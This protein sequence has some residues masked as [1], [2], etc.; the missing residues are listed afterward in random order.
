[1]KWHAAT[2]GHATLCG[3]DVHHIDYRRIGDELVSD[4]IVVCIEC[5]EL[6]E[7]FVGRVGKRFG[8]R[9][10]MD[11]LKPYC[12]RRMLKVHQSLVTRGEQPFATNWETLR[13]VLSATQ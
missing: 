4:L 5:H 6:L 11:K 1:M 13:A 10:V 12:I 9:R 8:R 3:F 2:I 7:E